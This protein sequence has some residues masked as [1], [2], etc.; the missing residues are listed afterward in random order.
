MW[1]QNLVDE[2]RT[3]LSAMLPLKSNESEFLDLILDHGDVR[4]DLLTTDHEMQERIRTHP[5]IQWKALNV[6][7]HKAK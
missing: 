2:C 7:K 3:G 4:S 6:R 5:G 1:A